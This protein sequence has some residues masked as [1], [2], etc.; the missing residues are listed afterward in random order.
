M[1]VK[2]ERISARVRPSVKE[3]IQQAADLTDST[4][5][6]FLVHSALE[7]AQAVIEHEHIINLTLKDAQTFFEA[8]SRPPEPSRT[9]M[10][11]MKAYKKEFPNV[12]NR[13]LKSKT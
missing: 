11:A 3:T 2:T 5:N 9:L 6:Q 13:G 1:A 4:M 8:V 10:T 12:E 7:K